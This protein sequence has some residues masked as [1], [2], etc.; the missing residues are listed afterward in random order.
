MILQWIIVF[1]C[2]FVSEVLWT[3]YI[4]YISID[5]E[6]RSGLYAG[7]V[8]FFSGLATTLYVVSM[9]L[10]IPAVVSAYISTRLTVR[11][12]KKKNNGR[13]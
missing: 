10:L 12:N 8:M 7:Y 5:D 4:K 13:L 3:F 9:W 6:H 11:Y 1:V 2:V